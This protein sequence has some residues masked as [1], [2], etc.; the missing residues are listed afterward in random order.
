MMKRL[1]NQ[2]NIISFYYNLLTYKNSQKSRI[3]DP[4][5]L[6][7]HFFLPISPKWKLEQPVTHKSSE[8]L[9]KNWIS[10]ATTR[11]IHARKSNNRIKLKTQ[12]KLNNEKMQR[13]G[14]QITKKNLKGFTR[15]SKPLCNLPWILEK[16]REKN[17]TVRNRHFG[18]SETEPD[19]DSDSLQ[20]W[21]I[22]EQRSTF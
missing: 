8:S 1:R 12:G 16:M 17:K 9:Q 19:T 13:M 6:P 5:K 21:C 15:R 20:L 11:L 10:T 2:D 3:L 14:T 22:F 7:D 18:R 4:C